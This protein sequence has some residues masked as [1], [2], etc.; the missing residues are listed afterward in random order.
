MPAIALAAN[1]AD[2]SAASAN[3]AAQ[4][5]NTATADSTA[6]LG[7]PSADQPEA[8]GATPSF[9][10]QLSAAQKA[11]PGQ[12]PA[13]QELSAV[14]GT[15][16]Q[17]PAPALQAAQQ[18]GLAASQL[19]ANERAAA[20]PAL[21]VPS[22]VGT[23]QWRQELGDQVVWMAS[24]LENRAELVLNPPQ[25]GRIEVS[26]TVS[27]D[28]ANAVFTSANP[29]VRD[30]L[31]ASLPRLREVLA[32]AGIQLGQAQVGAEN[33]QQSAQQDKNGDNF[34]PGREAVMADAQ[35]LPLNGG[36]AEQAALKTGRGL[37]YTFA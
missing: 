37:V 3:I 16:Q 9:A 19:H 21:P 20:A 13:V 15:Q 2:A 10:S 35:A 18:A 36:A 14:E 29:V 7:L 6:A 30:A 23:P 12:A 1:Q 27:G 28:Q 22:P 32:D 17:A 25:M 33:A 4:Q 8:A 34:G 11:L 24:R 26:L 5:A 31:E